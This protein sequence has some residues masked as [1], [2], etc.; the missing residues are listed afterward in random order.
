MVPTWSETPEQL[1]ELAAPAQHGAGVRAR[2]SQGEGGYS[3][4]I[5]S[6]GGS[7]NRGSGG[8]E[9]PHNS[10]QGDSLSDGV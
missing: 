6:G 2:G 9:T 4:R 7:H 1:S 10:A 3:T 8:T 5:K